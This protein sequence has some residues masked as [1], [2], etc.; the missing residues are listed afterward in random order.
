MHR[1][2]QDNEKT[3]CLFGALA[4][5]ECWQGRSTAGRFHYATSAR[6]SFRKCVSNY[7]VYLVPEFPDSAAAALRGGRPRVLA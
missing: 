4:G 1:N 3:A 2:N 7:R 5:L 6:H